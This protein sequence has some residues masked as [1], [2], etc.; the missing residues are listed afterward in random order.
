MLFEL[1]NARATYQRLMN[2]VFAKKIERILEVYVD[3]MV[4]KTR[5]TEILQGS[6]GN[7]SLDK[8]VQHAFKL[9]EVLICKFEERNSL[10]FC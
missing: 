5:E 2:K 8:E 4:I 1:K 9:G 3:D 10:D 6:M 7:L